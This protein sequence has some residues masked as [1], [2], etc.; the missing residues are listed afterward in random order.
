M[1]Q[2]GIL[3]QL[4]FNVYMDKLSCTLN[5]AKAGCIMNGVYMSHLIYADDL[6]LIAPSVRA[7]QVLLGYCDSFA[8]DNDVMYNT[9]KTVCMLV[10]PKEFYSMF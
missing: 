4:F 5:D 3:S 6:V 8:Q 1:R 10:R 9:K 2:G 7:L